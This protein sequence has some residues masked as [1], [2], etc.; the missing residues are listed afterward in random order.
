MD[1]KGVCKMSIDVAKIATDIKSEIGNSL[2]HFNPNELMNISDNRN[3][4]NIESFNPN[5]LVDNQSIKDISSDKNDI[6][7]QK[8]D[9]PTIYLECPNHSLKDDVHPVTGVPFKE[10]EIVKLNGE[11]VIGVFPKFESQFDIQLPEYLY[12]ETD[13]K[14][15][16][17]CNNKL[18]DSIKDNPILRDKFDTEQIEQIGNGETPDGYVW[19]HNEEEGK[20]QLVD[21]ETHL[22]T[23]HIGGKAVWGEGNR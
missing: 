3:I 22:R 20:M 8:S 18:K 5:K 15:F 1:Y 11:K 21:F 19:H 2:D 12:T 7:E 23:G 14:Q 13:K 4:T 9:S 6:I 10:K 16:A 17:E